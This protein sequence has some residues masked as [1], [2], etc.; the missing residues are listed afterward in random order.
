MC[1][2]R[3]MCCMWHICH[4][5]RCS[6][7]SLSLFISLCSIQAFLFSFL[8]ILLSKSKGLCCC[9]REPYSSSCG[10]ILIFSRLRLHRIADH[11]FMRK[12]RQKNVHDDAKTCVTLAFTKAPRC[13]VTSFPPRLS[14][15]TPLSKTKPS[16][17][18][19]T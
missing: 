3:C 7:L 15:L 2:M 11:H 6:M 8:S 1:C 10:I 18:G 9:C 13:L 4:T 17:I 12:I 5:F 19:A 14:R 16:K